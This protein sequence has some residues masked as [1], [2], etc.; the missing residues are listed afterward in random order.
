V[1]KR[2]LTASDGQFLCEACHDKK[3]ATEDVPRIAKAKRQEAR[4]LGVRPAPAHPMQSR[5]FP[6]GKRASK[7]GIERVD[8]SAIPTLPRRGI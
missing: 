1:E 2:K 6:K 4:D 7:I 5:G 3:S 8:K